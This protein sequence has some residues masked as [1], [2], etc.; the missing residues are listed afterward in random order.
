RIH[1]GVLVRGRILLRVGARR[2]ALRHAGLCLTL[3]LTLGGPALLRRRLLLRLVG[4]RRCLVGGGPL[5]V[6][7]RLARLLRL[8][9]RHGRIL[10][11]A[12]LRIGARRLRL[13]CLWCV[14]ILLRAAPR[15]RR[16]RSGAENQRDRDGAQQQTTFH[17][18]L[19]RVPPPRAM[20]RGIFT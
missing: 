18:V 19:L 5:V 17:L 15:L 6:G 14:L 4:G 7:I 12:G 11:R 3:R 2:I 20:R 10:R 16:R 13:R 1:V 9:L 8:A